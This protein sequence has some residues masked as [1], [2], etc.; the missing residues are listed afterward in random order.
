M[1][2]SNFFFL[3]S[4]HYSATTLWTMYSAIPV[5]YLTEHK[6]EV[7]TWPNAIDMLKVITKNHVSQKAMVFSK[8]QMQQ[9]FDYLD[10]KY[11]KGGFEGYRSL[12]MYVGISMA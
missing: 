6:L 11:K 8:K 7:K 10:A 3:M 4:Y 12:G 5:W 1:S 2:L 9:I